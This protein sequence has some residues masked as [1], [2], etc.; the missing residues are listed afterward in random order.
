MDLR[1][2]DPY[3]FKLRVARYVPVAQNDAGELP[4]HTMLPFS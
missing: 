1:R 2:V 3:I 4:M